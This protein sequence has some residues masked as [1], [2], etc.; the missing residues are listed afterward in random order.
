MDREVVRNFSELSSFSL[1]FKVQLDW[2]FE[3]HRFGG[4]RLLRVATLV[5]QSYLFIIY[6]NPTQTG[7]F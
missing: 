3:G 1:S 7:L 6:L 4:R 5:K 2:E